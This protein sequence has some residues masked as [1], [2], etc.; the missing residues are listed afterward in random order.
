MAKKA[1]I[2][3]FLMKPLVKQELAQAIRR[4]LDAKAD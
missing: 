3:Q 2:R 4:I 1:G